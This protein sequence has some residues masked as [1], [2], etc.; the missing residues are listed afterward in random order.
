M[1]K[2]PKSPSRTTTDAQLSLN[3]NIS[4]IFDFRQNF[5]DYQRS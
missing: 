5:A 3:R 1:A 2:S 4:E